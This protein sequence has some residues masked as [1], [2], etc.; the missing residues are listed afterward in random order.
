ME[1]HRNCVLNFEHASKTKNMQVKQ[2]IA[3]SVTVY[4]GVTTASN[5]SKK[6]VRCNLRGNSTL[7]SR[8]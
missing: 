5:S 2:K 6:K 7:Y 1:A 4:H 8:V 3:R